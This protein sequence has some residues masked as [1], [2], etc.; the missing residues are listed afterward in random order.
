MGG[1]LKEKCV[2][3]RIFSGNRLTMP[4]LLNV[5]EKNGLDRHFDIVLITGEPG[6]L[7]GKEILALQASDVCV[8][9][10]MTPHLPPVAEEIRRLRSAAKAPPLLVAGGPHVSGEQELALACGFD[11]LFSG[12]G[13]M[14]FLK[15]GQG[16]L[17][18]KFKAGHG[19]LVCRAAEEPT[20]GSNDAPG[21]EAYIPVSRYFKTV[22]PLEIS[23]GCFWKCRYCQ[24]G[25]A[26]PVYRGE[27]SITLYLDELR[28][29]DLP[30]VGFICPSALEFGAESLGDAASERIGHLLEL[31]QRAGFRFTEFGIFPS[32]IRPDTVAAEA[33][34]LLRRYVANRRLTFGA[35]SAVDLRLEEINRGHDTADILNAVETANAAG[36]AVNLDFIIALPGETAGERRELLEF[37]TV[38]RKK[39]R[40]FIQLHHFFPLVGS[41][42]ARRL[43]SFLSA[44][45]RQVFGVLK[46]NGLASDWWQEGERSAREYLSWLERDFPDI[47]SQYA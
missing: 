24:T 20:V 1:K 30:R 22:P 5:W 33:M 14:A 13:E 35:Q 40:V 44:A 37:M 46:K 21:W 31:C 6:Q 23:R 38:L 17:A 16:L 27:E 19:P 42:F 32:E 3:F 47:F 2:A 26:R 10:F 45:E 15:F 36:F 34:R 18:G 39:H 11:I 25:G 9:S 43:P 41:A 7:K 29:R 8:Y 4:L 12:A 28:R